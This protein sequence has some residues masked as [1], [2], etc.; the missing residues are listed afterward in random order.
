MISCSA[1]REVQPLCWELNDLT[2]QYTQWVSA[3][4]KLPLLRQLGSHTG[5]IHTKLASRL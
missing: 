4:K 1:S 3:A 2:A 5:I